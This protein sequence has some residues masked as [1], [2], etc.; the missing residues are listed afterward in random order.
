MERLSAWVTDCSEQMT[1]ESPGFYRSSLDDRGIGLFYLM[2]ELVGEKGAVLGLA[3]YM[4]LPFH[5][6]QVVHFNRSH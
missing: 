4:V 3:Y 6:M 1:Y 2:R 5:F